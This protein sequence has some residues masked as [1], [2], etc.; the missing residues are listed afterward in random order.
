[1]T[2]IFQWGPCKQ[3]HRQDPCSRQQSQ[4]M[5]DWR[6]SRTCGKVSV[7][8][9]TKTATDFGITPYLV[10]H[11]TIAYFAIASMGFVLLLLNTF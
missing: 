4:G 8:M 5:K 11:R 9:F 10:L 6:A 2:L 1:M 7:I 3:E